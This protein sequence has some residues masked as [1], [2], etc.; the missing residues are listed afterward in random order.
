V[1]S[2]LHVRRVIAKNQAVAGYATPWGG[3]ADLIS[4]V[5]VDLVEWPG[6]ILRQRLD[7][8]AIVI[9]KPVAP[10]TREGSV[11]VVLGDYTL[12][13]ELVTGSPLYPPGRVWRLTRVNFL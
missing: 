1:Q 7:A 4:T 12:D 8:P 10:G 9:D 6:M 5:D 13:V 11:H 3:Q 2:N